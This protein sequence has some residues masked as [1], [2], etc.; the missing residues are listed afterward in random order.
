MGRICAS[1]ARVVPFVQRWISDERVGNHSMR[2]SAEMFDQIVA[3]LKSDSRRDKD[4]RREPRVGVAGE[5]TLVTVTEAGKRL[6]DTVRVRDISRTGIG[7]ISTQNLA[8]KQRFV[9][10]LQYANEEPLWLVCLTA[11]C[12]AVDGGRFTI[13]AKIQQLLKADQIPK[14]APKASAAVGNPVA[15]RSTPL[16]ASD[17]SRISKAILG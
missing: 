5:T 11:Y 16:N 14:P 4:K 10:Q 17:I 3:A 9:L 7:L 1:V 15:A 12:R 6:S 8:E 13:G 2:L